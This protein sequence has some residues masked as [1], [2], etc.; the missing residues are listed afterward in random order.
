MF[1]EVRCQTAAAHQPSREYGS[2]VALFDAFEQRGRAA[3]EPL[4]GFG[5]RL[6]PNQAPQALELILESIRRGNILSDLRQRVARVLIEG[7]I[8]GREFR[9]FRGAAALDL[10]EAPRVCVDAAVVGCAIAA[11]EALLEERRDGRL[12]VGGQIEPRQRASDDLRRRGFELPL[13]L[14]D[15]AASRPAFRDLS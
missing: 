14:S 1:G 12:S 15:A 7:K 5:I 13:R 10:D 4:H 9:K 3:D 6:N 2:R 11:A 8:E